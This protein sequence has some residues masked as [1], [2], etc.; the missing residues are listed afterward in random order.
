MLAV[1]F[2]VPDFQQVF[3]Y[4]IWNA[5]LVFRP[6]VTPPD[7]VSLTLS[8]NYL[9]FTPSTLTFSPSS[10][11]AYVSLSLKGLGYVRANIYADFEVSYYVSGPASRLFQRPAS[12]TF[13]W[14]VD[15]PLRMF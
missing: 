4:G 14:S 15:T 3:T 6:I 2:E 7:N 10:P 9:D 12:S 5:P 8:S 11:V 13:S 1:R